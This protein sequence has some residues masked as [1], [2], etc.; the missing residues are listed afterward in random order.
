[1]H[2]LAVCQSLLAEVDRVASAHHAARVSRVVVAIGPLSGVEAPL[3][4]RAFVIARMGSVAESARLEVEQCPVT[5]WC[6]ACATA[7]AVEANALLCSQ[8]GGWKVTLRS[9]DEL[10]LKSVELEEEESAEASVA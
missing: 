5:V 10:L 8:C 9:G 4:D 6:D 1:M 7:S 2:E 3:L